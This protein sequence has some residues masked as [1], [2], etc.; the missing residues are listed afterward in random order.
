[1]SVRSVLATMCAVGLGW[2]VGLTIGCPKAGVDKPE[3]ATA[4]PSPPWWISLKDGKL[5]RGLDEAP[6]G[7][8]AAGDKSAERFVPTGDVEG[9]GPVG[10]SG[11]KGWL[12]LAT[13]QFV[14]TS[15]PKPPPPFID[16]AMTPS[17]F[18]PASRKITY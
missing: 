2:S 15:K 5:H 12:D 1:M 11:T 6:I 14:D 8:Y 4:A 13:G 17:G 16:G 3:T 18:S 9:A 10:E 7:L